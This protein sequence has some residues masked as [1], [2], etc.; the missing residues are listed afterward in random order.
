MEKIKEL[1]FISKRYLRYFDWLSF[2]LMIAMLSVGLLFVFSSTYKPIRPYSLFFKKQLFGVGSGL[3]WYLFFSFKELRNFARFSYYLFYLVLALLAYTIVGGWIGMGAQRWISLYV[4][5]FQPSE[6]VKFFLPI[7]IANYFVDK[8]SLKP[9]QAIPFKFFIYPLA[10]LGLNFLLILK[11]PDLGTALIV[12]FSGSIL[13]WFI[14]IGRRFFIISGVVMLLGA[15]VL[16]TMLKPY[17]QRRVKV[18]FGYGD[19][20]KERYQIEQ[21]KIAIG[22]GGIWGKGFLQGTQNKLEFLPE[23]HTDFIF[24]VICEE[25]GFVGAMAVILLFL[26]L[27]F[28]LTIV[29]LQ[30]QFLY[31]Q[32]IGLGL[33]IHILLSVCVNIGMVIGILPIVGIPLPLYSYGVS[34]LWITMVS[35]GWLNNIAMRR[36]Y[37]G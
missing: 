21:S 27:F 34:N 5:R 24:S 12:A 19:A 4:I 9:M 31:D 6:L 37:G 26:L 14:G 36:F 35:L 10:I 3:L 13:F 1:M 8:H 28:R 11:Q 7:F 22:S 2:F 20:K 23:D 25:W 30:T 32:I 33:M 17:Q 16:W 18:L 29:L 15:P